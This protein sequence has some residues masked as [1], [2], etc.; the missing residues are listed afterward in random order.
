MPNSHTWAV[1][2]AAGEGKRLS[3]LTADRQGCHVPRQF[4]ALHQGPPLF[5]LALVRAH[6]LAPEERVCAVVAHA[7]EHLWR[8]MAEVMQ[9]GNV[10]VQLRNRGTGNGVLLA[11]SFM[12]RRDPLARLIFLPADHHVLDEA[13]LVQAMQSALAGLTA[14]SRAIILLGIEPDDA[15]PDLG[16]L[17]P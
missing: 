10:I 12:L 4:C 15:D 6:A 3:A 16:Y 9:P 13:V 14:R 1:V 11:L 2:L 5:G 17:I 7:H 8:P